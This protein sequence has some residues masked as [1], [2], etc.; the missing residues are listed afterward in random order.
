MALSLKLSVSHNLINQLTLIDS[1]G[2]YDA[3]TNT[4]GWGAPNTALSAVKFAYLA[5]TDPGGTMYTVDIINDLGI[6]FA[7]VA[8]DELIYNVT[9]DLIGG[10]LGNVI[11]DGVY[12]VTYMISTRVGAT[13]NDFS[14]T[15]N[16]STDFETQTYA[17]T[18]YVVQGNT[19]DR[20][21]EIPNYYKCGDCNCLYVKETTT[22]FMLLQALIAASAYSTTTNFQ[23]ILDTLEDIFAFDV[24][25]FD[26]CGC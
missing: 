4:G 16:P 2:D 18:F 1:T 24:D 11:E 21:A 12:E 9:H 7:T 22:I 15:S 6:N 14:P 26:D 25:N 8:S 20:I 3:S 5:I 10:T 19:F 23:L 13:L 17:M